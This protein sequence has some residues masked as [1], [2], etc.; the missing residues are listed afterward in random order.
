MK[1]HSFIIWLVVLSFAGF[2]NAQSL[3]ELAKKEKERRKKNKESESKVITESDLSRVKSPAFSS[4]ALP[5]SPGSASAGA[6]RAE[7]SPGAEAE[8][9]TEGQRDEVTT[10]ATIPSDAPLQDKISLFEQM[11]KAHR[12]EIQKIDEEIA[13]NNT[14]IEEIEQR[15]A[16]IGAGGLPV[17]PAANQ[18]ASNTYN[19]GE[20]VALQNEQQQLRQKNQQLEAQKKS[21][22][23]ALR[24]KGRRAGIPAGYLRF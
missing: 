3:A 24:E 15:L 4:T 13:K 16:T 20:A 7:G 21:M 12:A 9:G 6:S 2:A 5:S 19:P 10:P 14:R 8:A 18:I 23:N 1:L 22:A 17:V 11:V